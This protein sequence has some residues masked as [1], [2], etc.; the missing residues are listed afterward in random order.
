MD[1]CKA[2]AEIEVE[3]RREVYLDHNATTPVR[4]EVV[5]T[6]IAHYRSPGL[7][8][9]PSSLSQPGRTAKA[10]VEDARARVARALGCRDEEVLFTSCGTAA[11][12][13]AIKGI[14]F[15]HLA[16]GSL[17][18][19]VA[20]ATEHAAVLET[21]EWLEGLGFTFTVVPVGRD[22]RVDPEELRDSLRPDTRLVSVMAV[23]NEIGTVNPLAGIG[24]VCREAGVPL[25]VDAIQAFGKI[26]L[27][28]A[29]LGISMLSISG[30]KL[31][32]PKGIAALVVREGMRLVPMLHGGG[33]EAGR[34]SGTQ[35]VEQILAL[36]RAV[37]L[38]AAERDAE[39]ARLRGLSEWFLAE[40]RRVEPGLIVNG[41]LEHRVGN[42]LNLG[43][44]GVDSGSALLSL[45]RIG[46]YVSSGSACHSGATEASHVLR[47][48]GTDTSRYGSLRFSLGRSTTRTDLEYVL[49]WLPEILA[50]LRRNPIPAAG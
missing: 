34:R 38:A 12:N 27:P 50:E 21:C 8:G 6:L 22:G 19:L 35:A 47:A 24:S 39:S 30:H 37:E 20:S 29:E 7:F 36:A 33:Q 13:T 40:L 25:F 1:P 41:S 11:N 3:D 28:L 17:G 23:N 2:S 16:D 5:E 15:R 44:E 4:Q 18:H 31:Y 32:A 45:N 9:N 26:P 10:L 14:A 43:F 49:R 42:C 48:L 46:V